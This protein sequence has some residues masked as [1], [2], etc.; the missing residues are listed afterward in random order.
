[1]HILAISIPAENEDYRARVGSSDGD[2]LIPEAVRFTDHSEGAL[3]LRLA[4][5]CLRG[6]KEQ[7]ESDE[8]YWVTYALQ[9]VQE[10]LTQESDDGQSVI[11]YLDGVVALA[12][13]VLAHEYAEPQWPETELALV[14]AVR[15]ATTPYLTD[16]E[17]HAAFAGFRPGS[18]KGD[19]PAE[20][21]LESN[22]LSDNLNGTT[23]F[24]MRSAQP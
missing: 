22:M 1:M 16:D 3:V 11:L 9:R 17:A 23:L 19:I 18:Q 14:R 2:P 21:A 6:S 20:L 10:C 12:R 15:V 13:T 5:A 24:R 8:P 4:E 7:G